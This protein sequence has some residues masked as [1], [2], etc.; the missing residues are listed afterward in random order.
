MADKAVTYRRVWAIALPVVFSNITV[1]LQGAVDTAIIGNLGSEVFLAA[2]TL[3][4][5]SISIFLAVFNFLQF[6]A[7]ALSAQAIGAG[8]QRRTINVLIRAL[9]LA[10]GLGLALILTQT[11]SIPLLMR[12]FEGSERAED[13]AIV[14]LQIR[15]WAAPAELGIFA[16]SGWFAGQE[17]TRRMFEMQVITSVLN[18]VL[19]LIFVL[20]LEMDVAG[21]ALGTLIAAWCGFGFGL[22]RARRRMRDMMPDWK[23]ERDRLL[24]RAELVKLMRLNRDIFVR[25][26]LLVASFSWMTRLGSLQG[27]V[28]L[29]A[30]GILNQL[31]HTI[32]YG[33]DG[34]AIAAETLVGQA[35]GARDRAFLRRAVVVTSVSALGLSVLMTL[36]LMALETPLISLFTNVEAVRQAAH[37]H[38]VWAGLMPLVAVAAYQ[39]D[40]VFVGA[41]RSAEMRN[42]M[43]VSAALYLTSSAWIA[44]QWG[45][46]GVWAGIWIFMAL[47]GLTLAVQYK[48][49]E[50][51]AIAT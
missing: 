34:L 21:V 44:G 16:L 41:T 48:R 50:R 27:D 7:G 20:G 22:W 25:S 39:L 35:A 36:A 10:A 24:N 6:G 23:P 26:I 29:A 38:Y 4:A 32:S 40:G 5:A 9:I 49:L 3:G 46:H 43:V 33:L 37:Q 18:I 8:D 14:Y 31:F 12:F 19:N 42:A 45:N 47:R 30:N 2:V 11:L 28:M 15:I 13:L 51:R 1:P 17:L